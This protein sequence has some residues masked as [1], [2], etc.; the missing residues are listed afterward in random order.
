VQSFN[1]N[2]LAKTGRR[3][4]A[5]TVEQDVATLRSSG[6]SN[7]NID[8]IAGLP[9]QTETTWRESVAAAIALGVPHIS[10]YMLE[11]DEDSRLGNEILLNGKR[12]GAPDVPEGDRI[13]DFYEIA[14]DELREAGIERYEISNFARPGMES[15]H[16]LK[17]W[18]REPY[19]GFGAD[20][21]S[22]DGRERWQNAETATGYVALAER[23]DPV[24][25]ERTPAKALE[26]KFFLG[27]RLSQ[28]VEASDEDWRT[29]GAVFERFESLGA[30]EH[31]A[32]HLRLTDPGVLISNEIFQEF[33]I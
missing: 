4:E 24:C 11:V 16:N 8:L 32:G 31:R 3:H 18:R 23:G 25:T 7:I 6:I 22:F 5:A 12:Y 9:G 19:I 1:K 14:V 33:L 10:V 21:H 29:F 17:Y 2:E 26:E 30:L 13:A 15:V 20:A 27:L 28:G